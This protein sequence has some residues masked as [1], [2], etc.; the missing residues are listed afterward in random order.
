ML[1]NRILKRHHLLPSSEPV[2]VVARDLRDV[3][4]LARLDELLPDPPSGLLLA[5]KKTAQIQEMHRPVLVSDANA[6]RVGPTTKGG[7]LD[8]HG[9]A[10]RVATDFLLQGAGVEE[11]L[12]AVVVDEHGVELPVGAED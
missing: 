12:L 7:G 10:S 5:N 3:Q 1:R 4:L 2:A 11:D 6:V 9:A 8:Y